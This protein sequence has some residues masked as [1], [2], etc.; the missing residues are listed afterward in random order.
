MARAPSG[1]K[2]A[3][4]FDLTKR[5][6]RYWFGTPNQDLRN[7]ATCIWRSR[8]DARKGGVGPAHKEAVKAVRTMYAEWR[9]D[10]HQLVIRDG[11][12]AWEISDWTA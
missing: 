12:S 4:R 8:E 10:Q 11:V 5:R 9:I 3:G 7:L 2:H 1:R 6:D